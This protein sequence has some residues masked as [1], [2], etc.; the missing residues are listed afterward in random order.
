MIATGPS[1]AVSCVIPVR[2]GARTIGETIGS[3]Q[4][5]GFKDWELIVVDNGSTDDTRAIVTA[6]AQQDP[7]IR[8][9]TEPTPGIVPALTR[10]IDVAHAD[11]IARLDA[12]DMMQPDRLALQLATF[13]AEPQLV[14]V[15]SRYE[16]WDEAS[17]ERRI[18]GEALAGQALEQRLKETNV[19]AHPS[20]MMRRSAYLDAGGYRA[21]F[22][23]A[24]DLDL[25]LRLA[26][27][28]PMKVL[29]EPLLVYRLHPGQVTAQ[30]SPANRLAMAAVY[31]ADR[32]AALD[33]PP[34]EQA[35]HFVRS[36]DGT[37]PRDHIKIAARALSALGNDELNASQE[38]N[39]IAKAL[40]TRFRAR[41]VRTFLSLSSGG[42]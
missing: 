36:V 41:D 10:G 38:R 2:N 30:K 1:P 15:A 37:A 40:L 32:G 16:L 20:V 26:R 42:S 27:I 3:V 4:M 25:W 11:L 21:Q 9:E 35:L 33:A 22:V 29:A 5:Q 7:R 12:D 31:G 23:P 19:I 34:T 24:E 17:G 28:G 13:A 14:L 39:R 8:L 6:L 18:E